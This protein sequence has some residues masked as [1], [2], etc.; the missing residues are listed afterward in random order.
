[1]RRRGAVASVLATLALAAPAG[2]QTPDG[3]GDATVIAIID[4]AVNPYHWDFAA[5]RMPQALDADPSND[6]PLGQPASTWLP[7]FPAATKMTLGLKKTDPNAN[8]NT[9]Q[10]ADQA[11]WNT[12]QRSTV[13]NPKIYWFPGTKV[14][15]AMTFTGGKIAGPTS[16]HGVGT[17]STAV[18]N[19][20][21]TCPEC[22]LFFIQYSDE[23]SSLAAH[24][25]AEKQPWI[26]VISNSYGFGGTVPK[27]YAGSDVASS[28]TASER[29]QTIFWSAG[30]GIENA[31]GVPNPTNFSSEKGP[32]WL[33]TV[34]AVTPGEDNYYGGWDDDHAP[35]SGTGKTAD[36]AGIGLDYPD[37][38]GASKVS[39]FGS[40]FSG[41]SNAAPQ[42][43][44]IFARGLY[45]ARRALT[46]PSRS[47]AGGVIATGDPIA[48]G[49]KRPSC[50][51]GDGRL[52][53]DE[54]RAQLFEGATQTGKAYNPAGNDMPDPGMG[55]DETEFAAVGHGYYAGREGKNRDAY[56]AESAGLLAGLAGE[57]A[58]KGHPPGLKD[59]MIVDSYCRQK[60]WGAWGGGYYV[61]GKTPLP[62]LN[63][64]WPL[65]TAY[66]QTCPGG[67]TPL[68]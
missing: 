8:P 31:F 35:I 11:K 10:T 60:A 65:R 15:G 1:M 2:A 59:W 67:P 57:A 22:L 46:G 52:T 33:V 38:Y 58:V 42:V 14:I 54:L 61:E 28:R 50:A 16:E 9:L 27:I 55:Y 40:G 26:D 44:G 19:L 13:A 63:P 32:D 66:Q 24:A 5:E 30:N 20:S 3:A 56:Q 18:G 62:D 53:A 51:L 48:C 68:S 47:Q 34:A 21:G 12:V 4:S 7:G 39:A 23:A 43:T 45:L 49:A 6:L 25:W 29:G 36:V 37:A 64:L 17:T 41:T